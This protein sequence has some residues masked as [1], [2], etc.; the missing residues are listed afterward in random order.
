MS[1]SPP[2]PG[3]RWYSI[4]TELFHRVRGTYKQQLELLQNEYNLISTNI[5]ASLVLQK[6][7]GE[8]TLCSPYTRVLTGYTF[9]E[10]QQ[11]MHANGEYLF[12]QL[13]EEEDK[14]RF[15]RAWG[16]AKLGEDALVRYRV[17]HK[18]GLSLWLET[19]LIPVYCDELGE[20]SSILSVSIDV[21]D[22]LN[23]QQQIEEQNQD[24]SD[25]TYM[26]SH[27]LKAPI[28][29]IKG[30]ADALLEDYHQALGEDGQELINYI[31]DATLRLEA[32]VQS[33]VQYSSIS[34]AP[35]EL[36]EVSLELVLSNVTADLAEL[37][38][39]KEAQITLPE[40]SGIRLKGERVRI[41]QVFSNLVG[42][43]LKY[44]DPHKDVEV[45]VNIVSRS[46]EDICLSIQ[47]NGLGIPEQNLADIFRPYHRAHGSEIE[48][49]GIGLACV[50][51]I[52]DKLGGTV[53][54]D[55][56][57]GEGSTFVVTFPLAPPEP[58]EIPADLARLF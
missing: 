50:K 40:C 37:Q 9:I 12:E 43:A 13:V 58:R 22:T 52:M 14:P 25:F 29:T 38:K 48:G 18:S 32:L 45:T 15:R 28:F 3:M 8:I 23:Y 30:M 34:K 10:L 55:S 7:S 1:E 36:E 17:K 20:V 21:T 51:K 42:N 27:D 33:V 2:A 47:D 46:E 19:R 11:L 4:F 57:E 16:I 54:A 5:S 53:T 6:A 24:L 56:T 49:S 39:Q 35:E 41:Y 26:V 31:S 44:S